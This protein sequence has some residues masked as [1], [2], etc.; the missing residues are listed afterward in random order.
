MTRYANVDKL[1]KAGYNMLS[2]DLEQHDPIDWILAE[3]DGFVIEVPTPHGRLIDA[4]KMEKEVCSGCK[5]REHKYENCIDC[6]LA[7]AP[8]VIEAEDK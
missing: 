5:W 3:L 6:A 8:I 1:V 7:N 2:N 4:D